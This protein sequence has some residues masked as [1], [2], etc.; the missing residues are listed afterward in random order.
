VNVRTASNASALTY[1][2]N[3]V[4]IGLLLSVVNAIP[5][6][7]DADCLLVSSKILPAARR[8]PGL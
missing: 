4:F 6:S 5:Y 2:E 1:K 8:V 3:R 7:L